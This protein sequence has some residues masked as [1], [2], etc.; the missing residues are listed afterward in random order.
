[1]F[2]RELQKRTLIGSPTLSEDDA[3]LLL[4]SLYS[5]HCTSIL[6]CQ[7]NGHYSRLTDEYQNCFGEL[8]AADVV[9]DPGQSAYKCACLLLHYTGA[10]LV[11]LKDHA[12]R[13]FSHTVLSTTDSDEACVVGTSDAEAEAC[14]TKKTKA[15]AT[16]V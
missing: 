3:H 9:H 4:H 7:R 13:P 10:F 2:C 6:A 1:M 14:D 5:G 11:A 12:V 8:T 15:V 16:T